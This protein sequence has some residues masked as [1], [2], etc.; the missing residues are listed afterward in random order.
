MPGS[1][2]QTI[3]DHAGA[4]SRATASR[5]RQPASVTRIRDPA[6]GRL[7]RLSVHRPFGWIGQT[8]RLRARRKLA[9][10]KAPPRG[11]RITRSYSAGVGPSQ[12]TRLSAMAVRNR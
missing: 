4:P 1:A 12:C 5:R 8:V 7:L 10:A 2:R 3:S 11:A 9:Q 6:Q